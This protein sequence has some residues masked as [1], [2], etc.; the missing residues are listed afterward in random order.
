MVPRSSAGAI[1]DSLAG[2]P[3]QRINAL[4]DHTD[5]TTTLMQRLL[6]V[7]TPASEYIR[8]GFVQPQ[9]RHYWVTCSG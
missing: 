2:T 8:S 7:S 6:H 9:R 4:T 1:S 5:L 3:A